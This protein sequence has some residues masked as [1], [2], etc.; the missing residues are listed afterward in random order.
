MP[1]QAYYVHD[2]IH[3]ITSRDNKIRYIVFNLS[4]SLCVN[5]PTRGRPVDLESSGAA[6]AKTKCKYE[7]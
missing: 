2:A 5:K 4:V 6:I 7:I 3:L 1:K